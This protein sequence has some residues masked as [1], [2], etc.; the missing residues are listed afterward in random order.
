MKTCSDVPKGCIVDNKVKKE[1][2]FIRRKDLTGTRAE[3]GKT[4]IAREGKKSKP[5][6]KFEKELTG[7]IFEFGAGFGGDMVHLCSVGKNVTA[8]DPNTS[9]GECKVKKSDTVINNY[10]LNTVRPCL[11]N[12]IVQ[13]ISDSTTGK[14]FISVRG[15]GNDVKAKKEGKVP[16]TV[17]EC[18]IT[19]KAYVGRTYQR[20]FSDNDL[21][22]YT[23]KFF[24]KCKVRKGVDGSNTASVECSNG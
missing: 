18:N 8:C 17:N 10:V 21:L 5:L 1:C 13:D 7:D 24:K 9:L 16:I 22:S 23:N 2:L 14:A 11:R 3:S 4:N 6:Q 20:Y 15:M 12:D 19:E